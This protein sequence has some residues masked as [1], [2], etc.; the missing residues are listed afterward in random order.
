MKLKIKPVYMYQSI[1]TEIDFDPETNDLED[2]FA[3][4]GELLKGLI[5]VSEIAPNQCISQNRVEEKVEL[6]SEAQKA[7]MDKYHIKYNSKTTMQEAYE[8]IRASK[9]RCRQ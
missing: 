6:A 3:I 4:Y 7:T 9:N 5:K 8:A 2:V 1:E